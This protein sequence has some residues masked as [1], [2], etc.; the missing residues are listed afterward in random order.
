MIAEILAF[1]V[2]FALCCAFDYVVHRI[3]SRNGMTSEQCRAFFVDRKR[4]QE[5]FVSRMALYPPALYPELCMKK[6]ELSE[7]TPDEFMQVVEG[8]KHRFAKEAPGSDDSADALRYSDPAVRGNPLTFRTQHES[9]PTEP[10][11]LP[12]LPKVEPPRQ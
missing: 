6:G 8:R 9:Q 3:A 1:V 10:R 4:M 11:R 12:P 7:L 2:V 5:E